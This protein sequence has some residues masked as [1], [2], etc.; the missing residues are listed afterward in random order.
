MNQREWEQWAWDNLSPE[1]WAE[2]WALK[3]IPEGHAVTAE[4]A[5]ELRRAIVSLL[6]TAHIR[7]AAQA[8]TSAA[9]LEAAEEGLS[10]EQSALVSKLIREIQSE[11]R[12][13]PPAPKKKR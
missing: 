2:A 11:G 3:L 1:Q 4:G 5:P 10:P 6:A 8:A 13:A 7:G 9:Y 12:Q